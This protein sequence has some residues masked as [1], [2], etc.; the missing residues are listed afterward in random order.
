MIRE[1]LDADRAARLPLVCPAD[2]ARLAVGDVEHVVCGACKRRYRIQRGVLRLLA[3]DDAFYEGAYHNHVAFA[4]RGEAPWQVW[5]L[6][7]INSGYPWLVRRHVPAGSLVVELGCAG[8]VSYFGRRYR[9]VGCDISGSSLASLAGTYS[10]LLQVDATRGIPLRDDSVDAI[11]SASFWEHVAP[12]AK[13][14]LASECAR[15]LR[16]G[17]KLVFLYDVETDNPL[18][19]HCRRGSPELYRR[20]FLE[21]DGHLGYQTPDEN[22][23]IFRAAGLSVLEHRG[24]EKTPIQPA[25]VYTKLATFGGRAQRVFRWAERLGQRPLFY[26]YTALLRTLDTV[27]S[28][29]L[30]ERWARIAL[31]VCEKP[32]PLA[33]AG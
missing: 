16:P 13:A 22:Q 27:V 3:D 26:P 29:W 8:G 17:G 7:L 23:R 33:P 10:A 5:P 28:P 20:Q 30:P 24:L 11:V 12:S 2:G 4:P 31:I 6:W 9:M 25:S 14:R 15:V 32:G 19:S 1:V 21:A 18:I